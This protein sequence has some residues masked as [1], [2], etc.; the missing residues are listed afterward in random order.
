[1][2]WDH[3]LKATPQLLGPEGQGRPL[4]L[5]P[6]CVQWGQMSEAAARLFNVGRHGPLVRQVALDTARVPPRAGGFSQTVR[7]RGAAGGSCPPRGL[8]V[9]LG[10]CTERVAFCSEPPAWGS[11]PGQSLTWAQHPCCGPPDLSGL[12]GGGGPYPIPPSTPRSS[13][14]RG[15][16]LWAQGQLGAGACDLG[17]AGR[18]RPVAR[19]QGGRKPGRRQPLCAPAPGSLLPP[20]MQSV[21][22]AGSWG[23]EPCWEARRRMEWA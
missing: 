9:S 10:S 13:R 7:L 8:G 12:W 14:P 5:S 11:L 20:S 16:S 21:K 23:L 2:A 19:E 1:M 15:P 18:C 17:K 6:S 22:R 4:G 3:R